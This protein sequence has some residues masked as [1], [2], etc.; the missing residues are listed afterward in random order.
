MVKPTV[1]RILTFAARTDWPDAH[2]VSIPGA[3]AKALCGQQ[4]VT[5]WQRLWV[6]AVHDVSKAPVCEA[7]RTIAQTPPP[8]AD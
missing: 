8:L 6:E 1:A 4:P 7:C 5:L 3:R 2:I